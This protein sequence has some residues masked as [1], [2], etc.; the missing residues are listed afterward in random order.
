MIQDIIDL[1]RDKW[2]PRRLD[3]KPKM[4]NEIEKEVEN[5]TMVQS[6]ASSSYK[7]ETKQPHNHVN[8]KFRFRD[9]INH[10]K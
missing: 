9:N 2:S 5:E 10:R 7:S 6:M 3:N 1:R 4:I 8:D